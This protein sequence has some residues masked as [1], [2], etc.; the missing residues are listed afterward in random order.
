MTTTTSTP[1]VTE[2]EGLDLPAAGVFTIDP[3]HTH[4]GFVVRHMMV[5]KVKGRFGSFA[6]EI[7]VGE[8][9]DKSS[10]EVTIDAAS[11]DTREERRDNHLRSADFF[12]VENFP[13]LHFVSTA[14]VPKGRGA[15]DLEGTLT[16]HGVSQPVTLSV[17][18]EGIV[19]D[20][21]GNERIGFSASSEI[22][23]EAFGLTYNAALEAGG[24]VVGKQVKLE[25][26]IEAVRK[27]EAA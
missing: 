12:D 16:I 26:E 21:Y 23:R 9:P 17:E 10:V 15:F 1:A 3:T 5:S 19:I 27:A 13:E 22:D 4:V 14:L 6:G 7:T 2:I 20:P 24:V 11:V 25:L 8:T 18:H